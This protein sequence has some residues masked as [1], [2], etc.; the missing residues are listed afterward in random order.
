MRSK[1]AD[2]AAAVNLE[3]EFHR[4]QGGES[5]AIRNCVILTIASFLLTMLDAR[6]I[7]LGQTEALGPS[8]QANMDSPRTLQCGCHGNACAQPSLGQLASAGDF[9]APPGFRTCPNRSFLPQRMPAGNAIA[10]SCFRDTLASSKLARQ[11]SNKP[12]ATA[13]CLPPA[14]QRPR[15]KSQDRP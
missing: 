13:S 8:A 6:C 15:S 14:W 5:V 9:E 3:F 10:R 1:P 4:K 11:P 7:A 12:F 2:L